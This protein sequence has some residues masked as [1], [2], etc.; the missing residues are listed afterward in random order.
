MKNQFQYNIP[1]NALDFTWVDIWLLQKITEKKLVDEGMM[2]LISHLI[3]N[4]YTLK[5]FD[6]TFCAHR[7]LIGLELSITWRVRE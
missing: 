3:E 2:E 4:A 6:S 5:R 1:A 7:V